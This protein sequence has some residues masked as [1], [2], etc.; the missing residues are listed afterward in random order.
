MK[1][2]IITIEKLKIFGHEVLNQ[3]VKILGRRLAIALSVSFI[4]FILAGLA[5]IVQAADDTQAPT[6][7]VLDKSNANLLMLQDA[8]TEVKLGLANADIDKLNKE[9]DPEAIKAYIQQ[10]AADYNMDWKLVYAIGAYES[11]YFKSNLA[12]SN[13]NF[14]GRKATSTTWMSWETPQQGIDNQFEYLK[15][16][17]FE[18]GLDSPEKM[19]R[20][21]C[22]GD[23]WKF[24]VRHIMENVS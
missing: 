12:Q 9:K 13:N 3:T 4:A 5:G 18:K 7:I 21:Y 1:K 6:D 11:G 15:T 10:K 23:T 8:K 22:E 17:Y 2:I 20:V 16:R 14:F 24:K 19:N